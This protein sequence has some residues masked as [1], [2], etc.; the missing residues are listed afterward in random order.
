M[1]THLVHGI[2][3]IVRRGLGS[4]ERG[5]RPPVAARSSSSPCTVSA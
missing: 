1:Y 5:L 2:H 3:F 4:G